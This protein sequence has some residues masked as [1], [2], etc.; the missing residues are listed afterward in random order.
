MAWL[1]ALLLA[2]LMLLKSLSNQL[3]SQQWAFVVPAK[4]TVL[5][6][7]SKIKNK[8]AAGNCGSFVLL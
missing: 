7:T 6:S 8:R 1:K 4:C 2:Q 5:E 3:T